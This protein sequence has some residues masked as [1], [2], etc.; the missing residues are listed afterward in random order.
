MTSQE[1]DLGDKLT[2][3]GGADNEVQFIQVP[4]ENQPSF[5]TPTK[6]TQVISTAPTMPLW[7]SNLISKKKSLQPVATLVK[8]IV[9]RYMARGSKAKKMK[10]DACLTKDPVA[11][12][13]I[14]EVA[15]Y[16]QK[17]SRKIDEEGFKVTSIELGAINRNTGNN[18]FKFSADHMLTQSEKDSK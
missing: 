5:L 17:E 14:A 11:G 12:K 10:I 4:K 7:L 8:D 18:F 2:L 9:T 16:K 6:D 13:I 15:T 3:N 1:Q